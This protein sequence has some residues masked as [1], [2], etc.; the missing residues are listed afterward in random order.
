MDD[1]L[2]TGGTLGAACQLLEQGGAT[3]AECLIVI[4]LV[5]LHGRDKISTPVHSLVKID[6]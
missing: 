4:E 5:A 3:I 1:L 6:D 2:A